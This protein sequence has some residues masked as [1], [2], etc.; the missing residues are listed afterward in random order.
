MAMSWDESPVGRVNRICNV[1]RTFAASSLLIAKFLFESLA[2]SMRGIDAENSQCLRLRDEFKLFERQFDRAILRMALHVGIELGG[3]KTA[4][5]H[6][7]FELGHIDAVGGEAAQRLVQ[8][9]RDI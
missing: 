7:A 5:D 6:V 9:R 1:R 8:R 3:G 2:E 4:A